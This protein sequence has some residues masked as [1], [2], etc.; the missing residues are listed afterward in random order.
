MTCYGLNIKYEE[1]RFFYIYLCHL[2]C[3]KL[4]KNY[5][6]Y[7][8]HA[9]KIDQYTCENSAEV[10]QLYNLL[11]SFVFGINISLIILYLFSFAACFKQLTPFFLTNQ[12]LSPEHLGAL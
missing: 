2:C 8:I 7:D 4:Y 1:M 3:L 12:W 10:Q 11:F 5:I 6:L 9:T